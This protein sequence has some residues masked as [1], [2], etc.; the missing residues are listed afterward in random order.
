VSLVRLTVS[1]LLLLL[2]WSS[3]T[4]A[5]D[6]S[7]GSRPPDP[8][9]EPLDF[10][11]KISWED[12][13]DRLDSFAIALTQTPGW[14]GQIIIYAGRKACAGEAQARGMRMKNYLVRRRNIEPERVMWRDA[15]HLENTYV[16]LWLAKPG[17]LLPLP[18]PRSQ[19]LSP[20]D[21]RIINCKAKKQGRRKR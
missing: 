14:I 19:A 17:Y 2:A 7:S 18:V 13:Q 12:E 11:G 6:D 8:I 10:F 9:G 15:G 21:V 1:T 20:Q 5:Q 4:P 3:A 16:V